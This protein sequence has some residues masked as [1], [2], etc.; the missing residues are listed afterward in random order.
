M[1]QIVQEGIHLPGW[2]APGNHERLRTT[3]KN[4]KT[5]KQQITDTHGR[6]KK[7]TYAKDQTRFSLRIDDELAEWVEQQSK[8]TTKNRYI[9]G[10]IR[11]DM[12]QNKLH[13]MA[14][15]NGK[16][17]G[18]MMT[19]CRLSLEDFDKRVTDKVKEEVARHQRG[20]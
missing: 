14:V 12:E 4:M 17:L 7:R 16:T 3:K 18:E 2:N 15:K 11:Q 8:K 19:V 6:Y 9:N 20:R 1:P 10:L 5:D 13:E